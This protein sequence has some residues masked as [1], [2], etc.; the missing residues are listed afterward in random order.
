MPS[1]APF[2][3]LHY[4]L[5]RF[6]S[7]SVPDRVRLPADAYVPPTRLAD[8]TDLSCP[9]YDVIGDEQRRGLLARD[10]HNAVRLEYSAESD[11]HAAAAETLDAWLADGTLA[12]RDEPAAYYYSH[13]TAADPES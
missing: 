13:G 12:R 9:P 4:S 10:E 1:V 11:P 2:R 3:G 5:D 8:L 6:G 7:P